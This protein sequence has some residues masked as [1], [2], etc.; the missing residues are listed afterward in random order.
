[1]DD[2]HPILIVGR[3]EEPKTGDKPPGCHVQSDHRGNGLE[4]GNRQWAGGERHHRSITDNY[5][6]PVIAVN[7][8]HQPP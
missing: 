7:H 3:V 8:N 4:R 1:M 5:Y 2:L 6:Y